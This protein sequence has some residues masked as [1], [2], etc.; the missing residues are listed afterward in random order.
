MMMDIVVLRQCL[1]LHGLL[2][3]RCLKVLSVL[4]LV[5]CSTACQQTR[6]VDSVDA[7]PPKTAILLVNS[8]ASVERY[9]IAQQAFLAT[10]A[11][12]QV[13]VMDL[14]SIAEPVEVLQ[15]QLNNS[16]Y[17]VIYCIGAKALGAIDF[18]APEQPVVFS[19]VLNW[20]KFE[21]RQNVFGVAT[22][23]VPE[24]QFAIL[25]H[26]FPEVH[27]IGV[28]Y[29]DSN[30]AFIE[31]AKVAAERLSLK[32]TAI[33]VRDNEAVPD[34]MMQ[35][36]PDVE[37]LW[38][39]SDPVVVASQ[40]SVEQLFQISQAQQ[41]PIFANNGLFMQYGA[42]LTMGVDLATLGRQAAVMVQYILDGRV[43]SPNIQPPA[44]SSVSL[45]IGQVEQLHLLL[46][47]S[48]LEAVDQIV[49]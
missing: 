46:N 35:L 1:Q 36:L 7:A 17:Q 16:H 21:H 25:K 6:P 43:I 2:I 49:D 30:R 41:K 42:T 47:E 38:L 8:N 48:S 40:H 34:K 13:T 37:V 4:I 15:D 18:L 5:W 26:I 9:Q 27:S 12:E 19:S 24:S 10:I 39:V 22:E 14:A 11:A 28:L 45:N 29:S 32:L 23:V 31:Q 3:K 44:G 20:R 33:E